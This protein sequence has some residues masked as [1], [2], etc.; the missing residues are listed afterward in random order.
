MYATAKTA[1]SLVTAD[2]M[3]MPAG[4]G[5]R[6]LSTPKGSVALNNQDTIVAGTNLGG[7]NKEAKETN[8]LLRQI[9]QKQG[10]VRIDSVQAGTAFAMNTYQV[11]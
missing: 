11:Q 5:D 4:Y 3:I 9:L 7:D 2:D 6:I 1:S 10:T 8:Q